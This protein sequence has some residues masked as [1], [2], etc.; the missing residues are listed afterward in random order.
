[1]K[2]FIETKFFLLMQDASKT[3]SDTQRLAKAYEEFAGVLFAECLE[4]I[5]MTSFYH[6]LCFTH[7][8]FKSLRCQL[9]SEP[10]KKCINCQLF[11]Q[12]HF[13]Y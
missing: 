13:T 4:T 12:S 9:A 6:A 11:G 8:E 10:E 5:D 7:V 1:M 3:S 2:R